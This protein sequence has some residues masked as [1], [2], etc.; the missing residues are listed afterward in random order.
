MK[1]T[2]LAVSLGLLVSGCVTFDSIDQNIQSRYVG[3]PLDV[4][5]QSLGFPSREMS[6]GTRKVY[7]WDTSASLPSQQLTASNVY[8]APVKTTW[9]STE[10]RCSLQLEVS[11]EGVVVGHHV[12]GQMGACQ[13][14]GG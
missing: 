8:G 5:I 2:I 13:V 4:A 14:Y 10:Y 1:R 7:V 11:Q 9:V 6:L 12:S 3:K